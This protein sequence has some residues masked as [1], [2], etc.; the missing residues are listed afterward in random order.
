MKKNIALFIPGLPFGG[1]ERVVQRMSNILKDDY[2]IF[3]ILFDSNDSKYTCNGHIIDMKLP[4]ETNKI[5]KVINVYKRARSL[6]KIVE[7]YKIDVVISF[8]DGATIVN[9]I[10]KFKETKKII[11]IRNYKESE[12]NSSI[13]AKTTN[14]IISLLYQRADTVISVS[15][16]IKQGLIDNQGL[17]PEKIDV[18][19]NPY[20]ISEIMLQAE[21]EL[22]HEEM[23]FI[24]KSTVLISVGRFHYQKA[25]WHLLK[26]FKLV[27]DTN[28]NTKLLIVGD[29]ENLEEIKKLIKKLNLVSSVLLTGHQK[30]P[31]KYMNKSD[32]YISTSLFE[33]FPNSM[34]EAMS[35]GLPVVST[36]CK[37]GPREIL[38][39]SKVEIDHV[40]SE[41]EF[42]D[43]GVLVPPMS[44]KVNWNSTVVEKEERIMAA[45]VLE[46][47]NN[48]NLL[49]EYSKLA[50]R[51]AS[52]FDYSTCRLKIMKAIEK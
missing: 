36:D 44:S 20:K 21:K 2:N 31:F 47:I 27:H 33:G 3:I 17:S 19:Y 18:V 13:T 23:L 14:F 52:E 42:G 40:A 12:K 15:R 38:G 25:Y 10:S 45:A 1:A 48:K 43:Y 22:S 6:K 8:L 26:V 32:L 9:L 24:S 16:V 51:R 5:K 34:V 49:D 28:P 41:T 46:L 50:K 11:S 30:N 35:C 4:A 29:G 37:S 7:N 39:K